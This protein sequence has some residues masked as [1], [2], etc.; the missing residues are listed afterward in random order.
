MKNVLVLILLFYIILLFQTS[1]FFHFN[2]KGVIPNFILILFFFLNYKEEKFHISF[3]SPGLI[4]AIVGGLI[5]DIFSSSHLLGS[6]VLIFLALFILIKKLFQI[7]EKTNYFWVFAV[8]AF[9]L[10]FFKICLFNLHFI[11]FLIE[12]AYSGIFLFFLVFFLKPLKIY[13]NV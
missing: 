9:C 8:F 1:F 3:F 5:F 7:F 12:F 11:P 10:F 4:S 6:S 2:I 13:H